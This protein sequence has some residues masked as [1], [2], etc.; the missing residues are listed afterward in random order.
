MVMI[1]GRSLFAIHLALMLRCFVSLKFV[2]YE[3]GAN[4]LTSFS[5][6]V[7][8][9]LTI[10]F[11]PPTFCWRLLLACL[12][13]TNYASNNLSSAQSYDFGDGSGGRIRYLSEAWGWCGHALGLFGFE[14]SGTSLR[15]VKCASWLSFLS[16]LYPPQQS[17]R[18]KF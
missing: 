4:S 18:E 6:H 1:P 9:E 8:E 13:R 11:L 10:T 12:L 5:R 17:T 14:T 7:I 15:A 2:A 16:R 3:F